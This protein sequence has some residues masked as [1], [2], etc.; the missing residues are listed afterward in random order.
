MKCKNCEGK[1]YKGNEPSPKGRGYCASAE[2]V[3]TKKK[4]LDGKM[5]VVK[6]VKNGKRWVRSNRIS[7]PRGDNPYAVDPGTLHGTFAVYLNGDTRIS[8][9]YDNWSDA[10]KERD[11]IRD[12][13]FMNDVSYDNETGELIF[14]P[15]EEPDW[16][17]MSEKK[18]DHFV[19]VE[20][21]RCD[22]MITIKKLS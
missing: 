4:G 13:C 6:S 15:R 18:A 11:R 14:L 9:I 17:N 22:K 16:E 3:D 2:P 1:Y 10:H 5:W 12:R 8:E 20:Q 19:V 7:S 21:V